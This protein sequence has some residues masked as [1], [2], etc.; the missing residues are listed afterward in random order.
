M[1][2]VKDNIIKQIKKDF[3]KIFNCVGNYVHYTWFY[4]EKGSKKKLNESLFFHVIK[5][6]FRLHR[7]R[8]LA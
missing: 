1:C 2:A 7:F 3:A 8:A 4:P 6:S 5:I